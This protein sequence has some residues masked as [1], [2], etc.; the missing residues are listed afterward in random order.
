MAKK[1]NIPS[2]FEDAFN[3]LGLGN[4]EGTAEVTNIDDLEAQHITH[5]DEEEKED[6]KPDVEDEVK[7]ASEDT[8]VESKEDDSTIPQDVLD[9]MNSKPTETEA[10]EEETED[11]SAEEITEAEQVGA[12]FDAV[13]ESFG[14]QP[15]DVDEQ[16]RPVTV[17][18]FTDYI[19][20]VVDENSKPDYADDRIAQLDAYVK[21]GGKFEDFYSKQAETIDYNNIDIDDESNQ[22]TI[23]REML[24]Y[25]GYSDE[26]INKKIERFVDADVLLDE[27]EDSLDRLKA[28]KQHELE[29]YQ[30]QQEELHKQQEEQS[31]LFYEDV[32]SKINSLTS[33]RGVA[34]PKEDKRKL[35]EY[36]F[37]PDAD[38][39]T[40]YQKDFNKNLS[41][42]LIESAYFTMKGDALLSEAKRTGETSAANK[43]RTIM[44][45][46]GRNH[47]S[48][49]IEEEK[50][51]SAAEIA[52]KL[53]G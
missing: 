35:F 1:K 14:W 10:T 34:I 43:L 47:S 9:R 3:T 18:Q 51:R 37:K 50:Q 16:D 20:S 41:A 25:S 7:T 11:V 45:N 36:I 6:K 27:A 2:A 23:V 46:S 44:R 19:R 53:F 17:E 38:G 13:V 28:I 30:Q 21:N 22:K 5:A 8:T 29:V 39:L 52:S 12:L 42:N 48:Y 32:S 4:P 26:Q 33:I 15:S 24:K 31:R 40:A 49:N